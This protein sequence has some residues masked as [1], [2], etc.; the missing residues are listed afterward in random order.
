MFLSNEIVS[1]VG[2]ASEPKA[3]SEGVVVRHFPLPD[4]IPGGR[5]VDWWCLEL[6]WFLFPGSF[7]GSKCLSYL[8]LPPL[9]LGI[10]YKYA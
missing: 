10:L 9:S 7:L 4:T 5:H 8:S 1:Q 2:R 6:A 3:A